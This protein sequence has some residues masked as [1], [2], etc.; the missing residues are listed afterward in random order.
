A[1]VKSDIGRSCPAPS[2]HLTFKPNNFPIFLSQL[3]P[4]D[5]QMV[6]D[7]LDPDIII[8]SD[9]S[10]SCFTPLPG[11]VNMLDQTVPFS[12]QYHIIVSHQHQWWCINDVSALDLGPAGTFSIW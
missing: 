10:S 9:E 12:V 7:F 2:Q 11:D 4:E 5:S 3:N 1:K 6:L 8:P